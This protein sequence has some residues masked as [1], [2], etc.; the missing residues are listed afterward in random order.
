MY[1]PAALLDDERLVYT[2]LTEDAGAIGTIAADLDVES[3]D[4]VPF[5]TF[6][7]VGEGQT[8]GVGFWPVTLTLS[9]FAEAT[10]AFEI[11]Q[12]LYAVIHG[13]TGRVVPGVGGVQDV[14]D[15]AKFGRIGSNVDMI[16]KTISQRT[17][18]F[19][20]TLRSLPSL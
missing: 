3:I 5:I 14:D 9:V 2:L 15:I 17:G 1:S 12:Q 19:A 16:G 7:T 11:T 13:W 6:T 4:Q 8:R 18:S 10:N 20:L